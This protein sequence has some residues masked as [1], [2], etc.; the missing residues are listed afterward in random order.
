MSFFLGS[1]E[2]NR[3][4]EQTNRVNREE[5]LVRFVSSPLRFISHEPR[6]KDRSSRDLFVPHCDS[7]PMNR[8]KRH[9][10]LIFTMPPTKTPSKILRA[11]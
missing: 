1:W 4:A 7:F 10:F 11:K 8:E 3:S 6:K 9:S 5:V 2:M